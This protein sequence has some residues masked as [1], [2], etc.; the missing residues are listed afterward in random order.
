M[1]HLLR[2]EIGRIWCAT[3]ALVMACGIMGASHRNKAAGTD[4]CMPVPNHSADFWNF[5]GNFQKKNRKNFSKKIP[6]N[7]KKK[8]QKK[9]Q[10]ISN[11][12]QWK[13]ASSGLCRRS[14]LSTAHTNLLVSCLPAPHGMH[15]AY[16]DKLCRRHEPSHHKYTFRPSRGISISRRWGSTCVHWGT[17]HY[18]TDPALGHDRSTWHLQS[19][20]SRQI[21]RTC[22][23]TQKRIRPTVAA[24]TQGGSLLLSTPLSQNTFPT[25][26]SAMPFEVLPQLVSET[27]QPL[28]T[29]LLLSQ[30]CPSCFNRRR[31]Y[32][33]PG[34]P[35]CPS[36]KPQRCPHSAAAIVAGCHPSCCARY[37]PNCCLSTVPNTAPIAAP[38]RVYCTCCFHCFCA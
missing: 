37:C 29:Q 13:R 11:A 3:S 18:R 36:F 27:L 5:F 30:C 32:C 2:R 34:L 12:A 24:A 17:P 33:S 20:Q 31:P 6:I 10:K 1:G 35:C 23:R 9:I 21:G 7:F 19:T 4:E 15:W 26:A 8:F 28:L 25:A 14:R 16:L 22:D 38:A